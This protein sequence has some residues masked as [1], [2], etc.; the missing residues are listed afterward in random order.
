MRATVFHARLADRGEQFRV[1]VHQ[2]MMNEDGWPVVLPWRYAG[3]MPEA[4]P[5]EDRAG[6]YKVVLH[7]RDINKTEHSSRLVTLNADGSVA[8][9]LSGTWSCP[10]GQTFTCVLDGVT[11]HGVMTTALDSINGAWVPCFMPVPVTQCA[12]RNSASR[13]IASL[14]AFPMNPWFC[15]GMT[16]SSA[17]LY[18]FSALR[19]YSGGTMPSRSPW[20]ISTSPV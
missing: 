4:V 14:R 16:T 10:D 8:G 7:G 9:D 17:D 15:P 6:T 5:A 20:R 11:F 19:E 3:E 1:R 13:S 12:S 2:R 18:A